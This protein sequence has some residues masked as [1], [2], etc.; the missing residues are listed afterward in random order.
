MGTGHAIPDIPVGG[1][2]CRAELNGRVP[3]FIQ[4]GGR[5]G[6]KWVLQY[7][8]YLAAVFLIHLN[9]KNRGCLDAHFHPLQIP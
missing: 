5:G 4:T 7:G 9:S 3:G 6:Y 8:L 1:E 2:V